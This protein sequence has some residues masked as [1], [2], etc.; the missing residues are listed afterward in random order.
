M[1]EHPPAYSVVG[2]VGRD[3]AERVIHGTAST[4]TPIVT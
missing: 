4:A 3:E 1:V 2:W